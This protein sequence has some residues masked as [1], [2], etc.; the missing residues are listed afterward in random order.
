MDQDRLKQAAALIR[1]KRYQEAKDI[2]ETMPDNPKAREWLVKVEDRLINENPFESDDPFADVSGGGGYS[3]NYDAQPK[4]KNDQVYVTH[5]SKRD[6]TTMSLIILVLYWIFWLP[7]LIVNIIMLNEARNEQSST[8]IR[9]NGMGCLWALLL[10]N[11][12]P[13]LLFCAIIS[14]VVLVGPAVGNVFEEIVVTLGA[15]PA[16]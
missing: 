11:V 12:V 7:G 6:Y 13:L 8:G 15:T 2:L 10:F 16:R 5:S 4:R 3:R 9:P 14:S 1:A